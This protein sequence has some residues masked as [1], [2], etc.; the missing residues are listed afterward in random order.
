MLHDKGLIPG[1][2]L[3]TRIT[4]NSSTLIDH[5]S[6]KN[7]ESFVCS[8]VLNF[9]LADHLPT[10]IMRKLNKIKEKVEDPIWFRDMSKINT[11]RVLDIIRKKTGRI[12]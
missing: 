7:I 2:T 12:Y 10:F 1:I 11:D 5:I 4:K 3:P 6:F 9:S 8:G